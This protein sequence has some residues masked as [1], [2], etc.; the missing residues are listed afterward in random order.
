MTDPVVTTGTRKT[1]PSTDTL[2][3]ESPLA[4]QFF[5]LLARLIYYI[6]VCVCVYMYVYIQVHLN[7]LECRESFFLAS[8]FKKWN[9]HIF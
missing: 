5:S 3:I 7:K 1:Q 6:C 8:Y 2:A 9:F 4:S